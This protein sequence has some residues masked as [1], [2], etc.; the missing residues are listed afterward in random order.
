[1]LLGREIEPDIRAVA[2]SR[3]GVRTDLVD[4]CPQ[5][6]GEKTRDAVAS[7][8]GL[9]S[10]RTYERAKA[11]IEEIEYEPDADG[12]LAKLKSG[13]MDLA[14][15]RQELRERRPHV[16]NNSGQNEWYTPAEY[17]EAARRIMGGIDL[18]PA[19]SEKANQTVKAQRYFTAEFDGLKQFWHGRVWMN[20]PYA[21]PL[22]E[23]F[24][25]KL[26]WHIDAAEVDQAIVLV[27]NAT[28]TGWFQTLASR[29]VVMAFPKGR[30]RFLDPDGR[31]GA[32]LQGQALIY[33][34]DINRIEAFRNEFAPM[35][36]V[37]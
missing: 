18:D 32:P 5:G 31:P 9:G 6:F 29:A 15:V 11:L 13:E 23:Q 1:M 30:V 10:G 26:I 28:E 22:I 24:C 19:S 12:L 7:T 21:Q 17:I 4:T 8:V 35:G 36:F 2:E 33:F 14:D 25:D 34:G 27:N 20:P 16:A 3:Q 37:R